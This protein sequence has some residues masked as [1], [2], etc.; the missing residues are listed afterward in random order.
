MMRLE[1]S[2]KEADAIDYA[3]WFAMRDRATSIDTDNPQPSD[4]A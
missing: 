3:L 1:I 2:S 4:D